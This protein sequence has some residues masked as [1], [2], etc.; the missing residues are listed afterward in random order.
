[1]IKR[2]YYLDKIKPYMAKPIIKA[3]T[4][5][6]R[7]GKSVFIRQLIED[8]LSRNIPESN[9]VYVDMEQ[10]EF[11]FIKDCH[12]L[13]RYVEECSTGTDGKI[14]VFIDEIQDIDEWERAVA[15]WSGQPERFDI[16]ITGSNSTMFSGELATKLTGRYIE[17]TLQ[18]LSFKEFLIFYPECSNT[19]EAFQK[20]LR[21]GGMPGLRMLDKLSDDTVFPFLRS[22]HDSIV[23]KDIVQRKKIRNADL[24]E[25]ISN[26]AYDNVGN[27]VSSSSICN[28]LK[29]QKIDSN[30]QSTINYLKGL[31][32]AQLLKQA[33]R[34][35][36]KGKKHLAVDEKLYAA[37]LGLRHAKIG[38]NAN[39]ISQIIENVVFNELC[40]LFDSV[41][42]G[43]V[44]GFEVDFIAMKNSQPYY[45]QVT[46]SCN[47]KDTAE[48]ETRSLFAI[49]D[50]Y[51]K[52]IITL[53]PAFSDNIGGIRIISLKDFLLA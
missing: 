23:L 45:F 22:I 11:N 41:K 52:T 38:F 12:T 10:L 18:P 14:Y 34:Y 5:M 1:M 17:F 8:L 49:H 19:D 28:Y 26:F 48:R 43:S 7:A 20:Y 24:L 6:R 25:R 32:E 27:P 16:I 44:D 51:P 15:S 39:D 36:I 29:S 21:Y 30:V 9:I 46:L 2:Q 31:T 4:G 37:D 13:N 35:D 50:N 47:D 53:A 33:S 40:R 3:V 42:I